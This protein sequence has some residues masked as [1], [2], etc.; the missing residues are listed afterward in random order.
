MGA[1]VRENLFGVWALSSHRYRSE[2]GE[3]KSSGPNPRGL[4]FYHSSM[5]MSVA[6]DWSE[7]GAVVQELYYAGELEIF[8][9]HVVHHIAHSNEAW[10]RGEALRRD[11]RLE[12]QEL[13]LSG[14]TSFG[15]G[16]IRWKKIAD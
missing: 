8:D 7:N 15:F 14:K 5:K 6:I 12:D 1:S 3:W 9:S 11:F 2:E 16:E 10:R 13:I 4:L